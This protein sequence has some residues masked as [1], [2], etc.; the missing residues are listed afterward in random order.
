MRKDGSI[1]SSRRVVSTPLIP[2]IIKSR[3][4]TS[5]FL[6]FAKASADS[7][8][9]EMTVVDARTEHGV[10]AAAVVRD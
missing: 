4:M 1:S 2:G 5:G 10:E 9:S 3:M 6:F 8:E 7:L